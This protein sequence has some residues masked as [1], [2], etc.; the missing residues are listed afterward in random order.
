MRIIQSH[1]RAR[2]A[3]PR[4]IMIGCPGCTPTPPV[5]VLG[6]DW[7]S[8]Q[9]QTRLGGEGRE[10][11]NILVGAGSCVLS[12]GWRRGF[13][14]AVQPKSCTLQLESAAEVGFVRFFQGM[15]EK[16]TTT[17]RLFD[18]GD[19]YTAH[20]EDMPARPPAKGVQTEGVVRYMGPTGEGGTA[21]ARG[22]GDPAE[23]LLS[24]KW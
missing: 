18:R 13:E 24:G 21:R 6:S 10:A 12:G 14:M 9:S 20:Q 1:Q 16:P 23:W 19:F 11:G 15:P 8:P 3:G 5:A 2:E 7:V 17:V 22:G 4:P